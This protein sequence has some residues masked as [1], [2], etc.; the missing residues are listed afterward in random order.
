MGSTEIIYLN[1]IQTSLETL[2]TRDKQLFLHTIKGRR[3]HEQTYTFRI[4]YYLQNQL[5][6]PSY[7]IDCEYHGDV[8]AE[9]GIKR[10]SFGN[11]KRREVRPDIIYHDRCHC[12]KFCIE[13]KKESYRQD[14]NKIGAYLDKYHY[15][16]GYSIYNLKEKSVYIRAFKKIPQLYSCIYKGNFNGEKFKWEY[17]PVNYME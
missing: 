9:D 14:C 10:I 16:E 4:A 17:I 13:V 6:D 7:Y 12:N 11:K 15:E 8:F 3:P 2:Y 1:D 5:K